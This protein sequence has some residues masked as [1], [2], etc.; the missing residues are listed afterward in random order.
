MNRFW[1]FPL[2]LALVGG[3]LPLFLYSEMLIPL[4]NPFLTFSIDPDTFVSQVTQG[5]K[6]VGPYSAAFFAVFGLVLAFFDGFHNP[7]RHRSA[8]VLFSDLIDNLW[9]CSIYATALIALNILLAW[10]LFSAFALPLSW[11]SGPYILSL[12]NVILALTSLFWASI[13]TV[14][15]ASVLSP[16]AFSGQLKRSLHLTG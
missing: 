1:I 16:R 2:V 8:R 11:P 6:I 15:S 4:S 13:R 9:W 12:L 3:L 14:S 10:H 5:W 7:V